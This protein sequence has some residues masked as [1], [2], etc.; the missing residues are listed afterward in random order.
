MYKDLLS[1]INY[2]Y[3]NS[4]FY[5][6]L[7]DNSDI[8]PEDIKSEE[9]IAKLPIVTKSMIQSDQENVISEEFTIY[10]KSSLLDVKRTSGSTGKYL[11]I[12]W[13][14]KDEVR[15]MVPLWLVRNRKY[16]VSPDMNFSSFYS[17][18]YKANNIVDM[19]E[20][21]KE[22]N[23]LGF[24]KLDLTYEKMVEYYKM[25]IDFKPVWMMLQPSIAYMMAE[26]VK[27]EK[28]PTLSSLKYLELSGEFLFD[29]YRKEI[30]E[31]F[32]IK[33]VNMYGCNETNCAAI[34]LDDG[35]LHVLKENV[36]VEVIKN[37]KPVF[38]EEGDIYITSLNNHAMPFIRYETGDRGVLSDNNGDLILDVKTG[39]ISEYILLENGERLNSYTISGAMEYTNEN[40]QN[41]IK[42]Y[43]AIQTGINEF[44][45]AM[46][47]DP[48]FSG[49]KEAVEECFLENIKK[50]QLINT[51]WKFEWTDLICPEA[52]TGKYRFFK[53]EIVT[54]NEKAD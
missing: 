37:G 49:W 45:M 38:D 22:N 48:K 10:P 31:V 4:A 32:G 25:L 46:V 26:I 8:K 29:E 51:N 19:Q 2:A 54:N 14:D 42:Q 6:K 52:E 50:N 7:Y 36:Y 39:R 33:S 35:K 28:L 13:Y 23:Y 3:N 16:K 5:K 40:M 41:V 11:K 1:I 15:S 30:D 53:N 24:S 17:T 12:Y 44:K 34:E 18:I 43:Q 20:I 9:D 21:T 47:I 27:R